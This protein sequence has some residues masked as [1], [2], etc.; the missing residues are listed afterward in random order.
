MGETKGEVEVLA[1]LLGTITNAVDFEVLGEPFRY[2]DD[3]VVDQRAAETM[4]R[5]VRFIVGRTRYRDNVAF[6][7]YFHIRMNVAG[8]FTFRALYFHQIVLAER[9]RYASRDF[10]RCSTNS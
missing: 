8:K 3:H 7:G 4:E 5:S 6:D 10:N 9:N 2:A 1:L